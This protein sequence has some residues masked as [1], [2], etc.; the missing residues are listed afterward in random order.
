MY[1]HT[2]LPKKLT[3]YSSSNDTV[4]TG[5][6]GLAEQYAATAMDAGAFSTDEILDRHA[7]AA[8]SPRSTT[9]SAKVQAI[10]DSVLNQADAGHAAAEAS[11][12]PPPPLYPPGRVLWLIPLKAQTPPASP[13]AAGADAAATATPP[14]AAAELD[15]LA[16]PPTLHSVTSGV[17]SACGAGAAQIA[18]TSQLPSHPHRLST[19]DVFHQPYSPPKTSTAARHT[20]PSFIDDSQPAPTNPN[21]LGPRSKS[22]SALARTHTA[23]AA[24]LNGQ[25]QGVAAPISR[26]TSDRSNKSASPTH[27]HTHLLQSN[28]RQRSSTLNRPPKRNRSFG[29]TQS[30]TTALRASLDGVKGTSN[31]L[32]GIAASTLEGGSNGE[33]LED[34][35]GALYDDDF[36]EDYGCLFLRYSALCLFLPPK[37]HYRHTTYQDPDT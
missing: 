22:H 12:T 32:E 3:S 21:S 2:F 29:R 13:R 30:D 35:E 8:T 34:V 27:P 17:P 4:S 26:E 9:K 19:R 18:S 37:Q 5:E 31:H 23:N 16:T 14:A 10:D 24:H 33:K 36:S 11:S 28:Q 6:P 20:S 1:A 7:A 15:P 25:S